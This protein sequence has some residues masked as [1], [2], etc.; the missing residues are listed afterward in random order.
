VVARSLEARDA[1][2]RS[3]TVSPLTIAADAVYLD[4][5][6]LPVDEVVHRVAVAI[7]QKVGEHATG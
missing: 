6:G 5:T 4:T 3:R 1:L 2:D 7:E